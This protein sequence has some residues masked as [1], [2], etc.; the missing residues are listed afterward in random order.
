MTEPT[1]CA[2][3]RILWRHHR[4][5]RYHAATVRAIRATIAAIRQARAAR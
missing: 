2:A 4:E 3:L 1:L 5:R